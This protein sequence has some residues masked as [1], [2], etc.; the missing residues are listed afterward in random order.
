MTSENFVLCSLVQAVITTTERLAKSA[1]LPR[2]AAIPVASS[3]LH[4]ELHEGDKR[5]KRSLPRGDIR[6]KLQSTV[7]SSGLRRELGELGDDGAAHLGGADLA[8]SRLH[9]VG[10]A[11]ARSERVGDRLVE[12]VG[13]GSHVE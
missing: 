3:M 12:Q 13:L 8:H 7:E 1:R 4:L 9:D 10:R 2:R 11:Q 6:A 5:I